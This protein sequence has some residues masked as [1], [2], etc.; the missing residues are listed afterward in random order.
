[1]Y[2]WRH[3]APHH[4]VWNWVSYY[5]LLHVPVYLAH[6]LL[7]ILLLS[8]TSLWLFWNFRHVLPHPALHGFPDS[9]L[10]SAQLYSKC[11][12]RQTIYIT[13]VSNFMKKFLTDFHSYSD[14]LCFHK[15]VLLFPVCLPAFV[16]FYSFDRQS[17]G[18]DLHVVLNWFPWWW[19]TLK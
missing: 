6:E 15:H 3:R 1:V 19:M 2:E 5:S 11:I 12:A 18:D 16:A 4:L 14:S 9:E 10:R 7:M 17:K 8:S 13:P